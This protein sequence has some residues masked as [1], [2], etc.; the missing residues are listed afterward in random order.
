MAI[1]GMLEAIHNWGFLQMV[2]TVTL[3]NN[4]EVGVGCHTGAYEVTIYIHLD[5]VKCG[6]SID[7]HD[8]VSVTKKFIR[9]RV[10]CT[11]YL[12]RCIYSNNQFKDLL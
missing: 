1:V 3:K 6:C 11:I 9:K 10:L 8:I 7:V 5:I 4:M 2:V 12:S